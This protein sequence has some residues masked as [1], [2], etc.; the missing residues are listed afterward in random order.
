MNKTY[1]CQKCQ[2]TTTK[3]R[4]INQHQKI[5]KYGKNSIF[6]C[7]ECAL[8]FSN[9]GSFIVHLSRLHKTERKYPI[10][11]RAFYLQ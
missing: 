4:L 6:Q 2:Y 9:F 3:L 11:N 7:F 5:H 1:K 10:N 8:Q